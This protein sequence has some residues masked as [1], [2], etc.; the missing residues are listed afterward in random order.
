LRIVC[1]TCGSRHVSTYDR[2]IETAW[3]LGLPEFAS[4]RRSGKES[5]KECKCTDCGKKF[6]Y[7]PALEETKES[8]VDQEQQSEL[9]GK[10]VR[11]RPPRGEVMQAKVDGIYA[12]VKVNSD[13][14]SGVIA[15]DQFVVRTKAARF[16][17]TGELMLVLDQNDVPFGVLWAGS[18]DDQG[19]FLGIVQ[20]IARLSPETLKL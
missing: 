1:P 16:E 12:S 15:T 17:T 5:F 3:S 13:A 6:R 10:S 14:P 9:L 18:I 8:P 19:D 11:L 4:Y 2:E 7:F 20:P